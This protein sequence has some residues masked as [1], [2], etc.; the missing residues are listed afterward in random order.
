M[1]FHLSGFKI[2]G[3]GKEFVTF[4]LYQH[5]HEYSGIQSDREIAHD[6]REA[7][8]EWWTLKET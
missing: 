7:T 2:E 1:Y 8:K 4:C 6:E 3:L 5:I